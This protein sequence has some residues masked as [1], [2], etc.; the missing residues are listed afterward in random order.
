MAYSCGAGGEAG[1]G[2]YAEGCSTAGATPPAGAG[3]VAPALL[4]LAS[5]RRVQLDSCR[6]VYRIA[7]VP[8]DEVDEIVMRTKL[9]AKFILCGNV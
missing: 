9:I 2:S 6:E 1:K 5:A 7:D 8:Y 4:V 3:D